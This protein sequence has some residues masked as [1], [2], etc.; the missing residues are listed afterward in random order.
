MAPN[1]PWAGCFE[2]GCD[3]SGPSNG[4]EWA[5]GDVKKKARSLGS[6]C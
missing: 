6:E 5:A 2:F 1:L 3:A 4:G